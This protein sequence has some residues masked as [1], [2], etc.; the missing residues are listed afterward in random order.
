MEA[1]HAASSLLGAQETLDSARDVRELNEQIMQ[2][3]SAE[4]K[5][6]AEVSARPA[7]FTTE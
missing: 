2:L 5:L 4:R 3:Q 1:E 6:K 7:Y